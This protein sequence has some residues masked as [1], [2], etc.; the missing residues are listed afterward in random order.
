MPKDALSCERQPEFISF[1]RHLVDEGLF[2][3][4]EL[5]KIF[6]D[7]VFA[8]V[9]NLIDVVG[10]H[11]QGGTDGHEDSAC[12]LAEHDDIFMLGGMNPDIAKDAGPDNGLDHLPE[13]GDFGFCLV[14]VTIHRVFRVPRPLAGEVGPKGFQAVDQV[15]DGV[16]LFPFQVGNFEFTFTV[17]GFNVAHVCK[18]SELWPA[19]LVFNPS[20]GLFVV[21]LEPPDFGKDLLLMSGAGSFEFCNLVIDAEHQVA[22]ADMDAGEMVVGIMPVKFENVR[23]WFGVTFLDLKAVMVT[24][25]TGK[26]D[27]VATVFEISGFDI[28]ADKVGGKMDFGD[29]LL[30]Y[31]A[32][33]EGN[34]GFNSVIDGIEARRPAGKRAYFQTAV[35]DFLIM[36]S[37]V[38]EQGYITGLE[39][40]GVIPGAGSVE[41]PVEAVFF[42]DRDA[43]KLSILDLFFHEGRGWG[44]GRFPVHPI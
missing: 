34:K 28:G 30:E 4:E 16:D 41:V 35:G 18:L 21:F 12:L 42:E 10:L 40:V 11:F 7:H 20:N 26:G 44:E 9:D 36:G 32:A 23:I 17:N 14:V 2:I 27:P 33:M 25:F 13:F 29:E 24:A 1:G 8:E 39:A 43:F 22:F 15:K 6:L 37:T 3:F 19:E 31:F 5:V 38:E